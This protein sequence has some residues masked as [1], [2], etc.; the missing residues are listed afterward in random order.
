VSIDPAY[1]ATALAVA[2]AITV[3][4]RAIPFGLKNA[5]KESELLAD[6]GRWM[7]LGAI[8]ILATYC[9]TTIDVTSPTHGVPELVGVAATVAVH[10]WRHN[11]VLSLVIGTAACLALSHWLPLT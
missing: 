7:P 8:T 2:V 9:L 3:S 11:L 10:L 4:L 5:M 6:V 1:V